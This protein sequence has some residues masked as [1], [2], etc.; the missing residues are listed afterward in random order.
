MIYGGDE[1]DSVSRFVVDHYVNRKPPKILITPVPISDTIHNWLNERREGSVD[2]RVPMRG[3]FVTLK[4]LARQNAMMQVERLANKSSGS[5][6]QRAA[7]DGAKILGMDSLNHIVC[8]DMAQFLGES[9]VGASVCLRNGK[10]SKKEYRTYTVKGDAMD[11]LRM[12]SEVVERWIKRVEDWPDLLL[13]DGGETHLSFISKLLEENGVGDKMQ[14]ASLAKR[15]ETIHRQNK[16]DIILDRRGRV[17]VYARDGKPNKIFV[18]R[19]FN[20]ILPFFGF[21]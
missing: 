2:V 14:L 11:D 13:I 1:G 7:D 4:N 18:P 8:F 6:E 3:D 10:P 16:D 12:M 15:E 17:L 9:R 19:I 21:M 20:T 5:L